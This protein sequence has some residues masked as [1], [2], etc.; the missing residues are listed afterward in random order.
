MEAN[1]PTSTDAYMVLVDNRAPNASNTQIDIVGVN[2]LHYS[3]LMKEHIPVMENKNG[4]AD[5]LS[6]V[7]WR[8]HRA[9]IRVLL[10]DRMGAGLFQSGTCANVGTRLLRVF[11]LISSP[12]AK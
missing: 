6:N 7:A 9:C 3:P 2:R 4:E 12:S 8:I 11:L 10:A 1:L 5:T